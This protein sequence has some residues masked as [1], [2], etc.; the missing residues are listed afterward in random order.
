MEGILVYNLYPRLVGKF[1]QMKS[2]AIRAKE[3]GFQYV[4][5]NPVA[6][7]GFSGSSYAIKNHYLYHPIHYKGWPLDGE[8]YSEENL[9]KNKCKSHINIKQKWES[10]FSFFCISN[11]KKYNK[12]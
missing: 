10:I 5:L 1:E 3:M 7:P 12:K 6:L 2:H 8:D 11:T 9:S 4:Y